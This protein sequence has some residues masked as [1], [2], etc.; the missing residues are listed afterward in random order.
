MKEVFDY[1]VEVESKIDL[2]CD[3]LLAQ[4]VR[5]QQSRPVCVAGFRQYSRL[6]SSVSNRPSCLHVMLLAWK[7]ASF[8][9]LEKLRALSS[10]KN[11]ILNAKLA[12]FL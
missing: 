2:L 4:N 5:A 3:K 12:I 1:L 7:C 10:V 6:V 8:L 11:E 9:S